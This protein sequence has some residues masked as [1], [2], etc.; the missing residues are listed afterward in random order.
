[1]VNYGSVISGNI[2]TP[3]CYTRTIG[4]CMP[5]DNQVMK[6][7]NSVNQRDNFLLKNTTGIERFNYQSFKKSHKIGTFNQSPGVKLHDALSSAI[8]KKFALN[9]RD[10]CEAACRVVD[11]G[12]S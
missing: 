11:R 12:N 2:P 4:N 7:V 5:Y 1:M 8:K 3:R 10:A 6:D 9:R